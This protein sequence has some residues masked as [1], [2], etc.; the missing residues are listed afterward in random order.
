MAF[1]FVLVCSYPPVDFLFFSDFIQI[2]G[3]SIILLIKFLF[4]FKLITLLDNLVVVA[5]SLI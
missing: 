2:P 1:L 3:E 5:F 4:V